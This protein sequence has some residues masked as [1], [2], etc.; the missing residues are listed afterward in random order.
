MELVNEPEVTVAQAPEFGFGQLAEILAGDADRAVA[1]VIEPA[2]QVH[3]GRFAGSGRAE[4]GVAFTAH[5]AK[6]DALEHL[7]VELSLAKSLADRA[8]LD[9]GCLH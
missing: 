6:V 7:D 3:Q 4:N 1:D 8:G 2:E 9:G 5:D